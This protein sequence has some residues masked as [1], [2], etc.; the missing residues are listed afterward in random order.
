MLS[1]KLHTRIGEL[2]LL[3]PVAGHI[4]FTTVAGQGWL[5]GPKPSLDAACHVASASDVIKLSAEPNP[6]P[7]RTPLLEG[8]RPVTSWFEPVRVRG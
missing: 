4:V 5:A 3:L 7:E 1:F 6:R 2:D 8:S